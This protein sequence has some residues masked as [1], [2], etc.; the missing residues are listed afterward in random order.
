MKKYNRKAFTDY[1][2]KQFAVLDKICDNGNFN[3]NLVK[4]RLTSISDAE[5]N[6]I[7]VAIDNR[8]PLDGFGASEFIIPYYVDDKFKEAPDMNALLKL[9]DE[10]GAEL[11]SYL[12]SPDHV[13]GEVSRSPERRGLMLLDTRRAIQNIADKLSVAKDGSKRDEL[14]GQV[15]GSS[16]GSSMSNP[17]LG[18]LLGRGE[19]LVS[20][21]YMAGRGS[22]SGATNTLNSAIA[23]HGGVSLETVLDGSN[24]VGVTQSISSLL[25]GMMLGSN[26]VSN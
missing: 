14:T 16:K 17:E 24:G 7:M 25:A 18:C 19:E 12:W 23:T 22:D 6:Q 8:A 20:V 5:I 21:E 10:I 1:V 9:G 4:D 15:T 26:M 2:V 13:T 11:F 3:S